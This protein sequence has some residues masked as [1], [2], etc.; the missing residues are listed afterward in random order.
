MVWGFGADKQQLSPP[1]DATAPL[2]YLRGAARPVL[3]TQ[4]EEGVLG[5]LSFT[6]SFTSS[7]LT[8]FANLM[9]LVVL[10]PRTG[11]FFGGKQQVWSHTSKPPKL[12]GPA[13][14]KDCGETRAEGIKKLLQE[15]EKHKEMAVPLGTSAL[16]QLLEPVFS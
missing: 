14:V 13:R 5:V 4:R 1:G 9:Q 12:S 3:G 8:L 16:S 6:S 15:K 7:F 11:S 10:S 2:E